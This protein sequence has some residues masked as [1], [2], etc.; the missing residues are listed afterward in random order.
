MKTVCHK[1]FE[2]QS[3][4]GKKVTGGFDGG[5]ISSDGGGLLL[6]E[7]DLQHGVTSHVSRA[8]Q[9]K[10][11]LHQ[12]R[13]SMETLLRQRIYGICLG[14]ED[15]NDHN[16]LRKDP[17]LKTACDKL[18]D[19]S[20]DLASQPTLSRL[21]NQ[22][23]SRELIR[24]SREL[25]SLYLQS[26]SGKRDVIIIDIDSTDD[27]THG[28]QQLSLFHGYY[29]Q[30]MYHPLM[31]FDGLTGFPMA[32]VLRP[33]NSHASKGA[34]G[35][36][37]RIIQRLQGA[38]PESAILVR[39]DGGF[40]LPGLYEL[41]E[42]LDVHY[43]IGLITNSRLKEASDSLLDQAIEKFEEKGEKQRLFTS[44]SYQADSWEQA[45]RVIA[46]AECMVQGTNRRFV[47]TNLPGDPELLYDDIYVHRGEME[48]RI[49]EL[50]NHLKADRLSCHCFHANQFR[51]LLHTFAY[52]LLWFLREA[53]QKSS[54][55]CAQMD[56]I[57]V[58]ILKVGVRVVESSRRVW[59]HLS[60]AYP[61]QELFVSLLGK[62]QRTPV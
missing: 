13:H 5:K 52:C 3:L 19:S 28:V 62:I 1:R 57:Q 10:R 38:H 51:L 15:A 47:V 40:A 4:F 44:F 27:P 25:F 11:V 59:L 31:I 43:L 56:T 41:C 22:V 32:V 39:A 20:G 21:E 18:P 60:S 54:L 8:L 35:I 24:L 14:Y 26:H 36:L 9:D 7:L 50:K 29:G 37:R 16:T 17:V 61:L 58:K 45:R 49:K 23:N 2:F 12:V 30:H 34:V 6:R 33:G 48:N 55:C 53:L 46:K 42:E